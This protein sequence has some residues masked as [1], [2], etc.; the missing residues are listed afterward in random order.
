M[1]QEPADAGEGA[2]PKLIIYSAEQGEYIY[3]LAAG[4]DSANADESMVQMIASTFAV[5]N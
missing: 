2:G 1:D 5:S 3:S 4:F